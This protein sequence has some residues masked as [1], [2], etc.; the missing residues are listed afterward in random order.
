MPGTITVSTLCR[1]CACAH[2]GCPVSLHP[3]P[4]MEK[5]SPSVHRG[6]APCCAVAHLLALHDNPVR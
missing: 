4:E 2:E 6:Q 3:S 5:T 1:M